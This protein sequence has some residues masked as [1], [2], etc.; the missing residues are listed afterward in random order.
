M[1]YLCNVTVIIYE[2]EITTNMDVTCNVHAIQGRI[3]GGLKGAIAPGLTYK[4]DLT[5]WK[6]YCWVKKK[7]W[8][9]EII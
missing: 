2:C 1:L 9:H 8:K 7:R 4:G 3:K 5:R 6:I